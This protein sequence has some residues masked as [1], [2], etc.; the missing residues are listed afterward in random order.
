MYLDNYD[1]RAL[2][3]TYNSFFKFWQNNLFTYVEKLFTWKCGNVPQKE[4]ETRLILF[5]MVGIVKKEG[6]VFPVKADGLNGQTI[7]V[8]E[9]KHFNWTTPIAWQGVGN[10]GEDAVLIN[11]TALRNPTLFL[12]NHYAQLL[13]QNEITLQNT[14]INARRGKTLEAMSDKMAQEA[15]RYENKIYNG[16]PDVIVDPSFAGINILDTDTKGME[17]IKDIWEVRTELLYA[18]FEDLGIK[19]ANKKRERMITDEATASDKLLKLNLKDMLD[20]RKKGAA[21]VN[22]MFGLD[23]EVECNIDYDA[24]GTV[25]SEEKDEA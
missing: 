13:A 9:F 7:Y 11:N 5:G 17:Y 16:E 15:R 19:T 6:L 3:P 14:M 22:N 25:E 8:D 23:W 4:I 21:A 1:C 24:D 10:I 20:E 2:K 18:F 12:I